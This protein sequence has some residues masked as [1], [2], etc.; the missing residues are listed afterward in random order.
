MRVYTK[1]QE[2]LVGL[3]ISTH[4]DVQGKESDTIGAT[5]CRKNTRQSYDSGATLLTNTNPRSL[6]DLVQIRFETRT[7]ALWPVGV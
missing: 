4:T 7:R 5:Y 2:Q 3:F 6:F 1:E